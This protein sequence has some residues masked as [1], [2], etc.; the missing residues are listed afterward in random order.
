MSI[1]SITTN[2][3][4]KFINP[5]IVHQQTAVI[6]PCWVRQRLYITVQGREAMKICVNSRAQERLKKHQHVCLSGL[7]PSPWIGDEHLRGLQ[8][9]GLGPR[10]FICSTGITRARDDNLGKRTSFTWDMSAQQWPVPANGFSTKRMKVNM[11]IVSEYFNNKTC[12]HLMTTMIEIS[13]I[14][15]WTIPSASSE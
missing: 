4:Q 7:V 12:C 14:L 11:F 15:V 5:A 1:I 10:F 9:E 3:I 8:L 13:C 2:A 6:D